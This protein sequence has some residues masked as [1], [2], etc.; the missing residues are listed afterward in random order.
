MH[1]FRFAILGAVAALALGTAS[2]VAMQQS[3]GGGTDPD[4]HGDNV[5]SAARTTC[6]HG[7]NGVHGECVSAVASSKSEGAEEKSEVN[8][9]KAADATEDASEPNVGNL[10]AVQKK[11]AKAADKKEDK[12][13]HQK[14]AACVSGESE[15]PEK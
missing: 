6:P 3:A 1:R 5:A 15:T 7:P 11:P 14:F 9:C 10:P 12:G 13:E 8:A 2:A 4:Q